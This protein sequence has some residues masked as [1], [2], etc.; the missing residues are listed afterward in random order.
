MNAL[1]AA[2]YPRANHTLVHLSDTHFVPPGE[3]LSGVAPVR[4]H[5]EGLLEDLV[6]TNLRPEALIF[7]GDLADRGRHP[8]IGSCA[9]W[10]SRSPSTS[11]PS[12]SG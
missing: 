4:E 5:L 9:S 2:E 12:S 11:A 8:P 10:S 6:A 7:T 1:R 3:L